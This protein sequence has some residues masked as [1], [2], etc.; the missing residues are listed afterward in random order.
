M[1]RS[2]NGES[3]VDELSAL[4][5][6]TSTTFKTRVLGWANDIIFDIATR[7]DWGHH[8][9]K[10]K[11][12]LALGEEI[13]NL[14]IE[15]PGAATI[16]LAA[17]GSL[18]EGSTYSVLFTFLQSNGVETLAGEASNS[19]TTL[20]DAKTISIEDIPTSPESMV[21]SRNVY[22]KK[23]DGEYYFHSNI[24]DNF[25]TTL[26]ISTDTESVIQPPDYEAIRRIKGAPFF[27]GSPSIYLKY[28]D[29]DQ[30]RAL[31]QGL[32]PQGSPEYFSPVDGNTFV[33]YPSPS[34]DMEISFNYYRY[35]K[36]LYYTSD[37]QPDLPINL[38]P[39]LKAGV[40]ALGYEYRDRA[41]QELKKANY[42]NALVDSINR[43]ARVANVEYVVKDV[44]GN[45]D[46]VEVN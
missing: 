28:K 21:T 6:D 34:F 24:D 25:S 8:L 7:H 4:L 2:W 40:I 9:V 45:F 17:D 20:A 29:E 38:K 44:Y 3:L 13:H 19:V 31:A 39:A 12:I 5:G 1:S 37:S 14:E 42:E 11:K 46:G 33:T 16:S 23:D 27:E 15:S 10:G 26:T 41:G 22:L 36:K 43:G 32:W 18:T 35:P 30:L